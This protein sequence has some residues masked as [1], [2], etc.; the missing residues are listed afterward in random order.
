M[1]QYLKKIGKYD[2]III[3]D[4]GYVQQSRDEMEV[5]FTLLADRYERS[6]CL[7]YAIDIFHFHLFGQILLL[8]KNER[9]IS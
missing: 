4:I 3:D 1:S 7:C 6:R 2:A 8:S 9:S 5:L